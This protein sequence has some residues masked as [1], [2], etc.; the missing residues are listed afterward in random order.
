MSLDSNLEE[1]GNVPSQIKYLPEIEINIVH[2]FYPPVTLNT[3]SKPLEIALVTSIEGVISP[4]Y[5]FGLFDYGSFHTIRNLP[6]M[7]LVYSKKY[8]PKTEGSEVDVFTLS[9][10]ASYETIKKLG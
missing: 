2:H 8:D 3:N 1:I 6:I 7:K 5:V 9:N 4:C 10:I